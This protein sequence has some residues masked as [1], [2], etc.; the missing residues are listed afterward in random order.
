MRKLSTM[1]LPALCIAFSL[2][3]AAASRKIV[4][5][6]RGASGY[7]PE[8]TLEAVAMAYAMGA[9]F[10]EQDVVLSKDGVPVVLHDITLDAVTDVATRFPD[11]RREDGRYYALDFSLSEI[12]QLR[13]TERFDRATGQAVYPGRFPVRRAA[14]E[15][16][17]LEEELQLIQ[18]LNSSTGKNVG[19]YPEIKAPAWHR[20][21]GWDISRIVLAVI[22]RYGYRTK[23]DN[24]YLQCFDFAEVKRI[25]RELGYQGKLVQLVDGAGSF[26][27]GRLTTRA[28]LE[29]AAA[30]VDALG[31]AIEQ[32]VTG[33]AK[34]VW[35]VS[36]LVRNAHAVGLEVH[37][38]TVRADSL[39]P[40]AT[41]FEELLRILLIEAGVDGVFTD[42][43]DRAAAFLRSLRRT[44]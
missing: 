14:F 3:L 28:G 4:V 12:R 18:G 30:V 42:H 44:E 7:L 22:G 26:E 36:D 33:P 19:V 25:R 17:T 31:P 8:H 37:P 39:P 40:Y 20:Q 21:Q 24:I 41:S 13:V 15:V 10:V 35:Q 11:R 38:F 5:A 32:V 23:D 1:W 9:D 34:G 6:H 16:P 29:E 43:P 27:Q 2:P